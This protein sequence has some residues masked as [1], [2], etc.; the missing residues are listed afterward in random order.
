M[1]QFDLQDYLAHRQLLPG[2][3]PLALVALV[4]VMDEPDPA[5]DQLM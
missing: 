4:M 5:D 1:L 3:I 2:K